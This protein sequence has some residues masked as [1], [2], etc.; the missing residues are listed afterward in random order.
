MKKIIGIIDIDGVITNLD[1][2]KNKAISTKILN[3]SH[4]HTIDNKL[5]NELFYKICLMVVKNYRLRPFVKEVITALKNVGTEINIV[6]KRPFATDDCKEGQMI[7]TLTETLL[8]D[9]EIPYDR[10]FYSDGDKSFECDDLNADFIIEDNPGTV[11]ELSKHTKVLLFDTPYNQGIEGENI[12]RVANW[13]EV[14]QTIQRLF[15]L[16]ERILKLNEEN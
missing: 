7:R 4:N 6:T 11:E 14:Y 5:L 8:D 9:A 13:V 15:P 16:K 12:Y 2:M 10:L 3:L 1:F